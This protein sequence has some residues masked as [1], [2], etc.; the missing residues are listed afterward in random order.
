MANS[1]IAVTN[2]SSSSSNPTIYVC[3]SIWGGDQS[4]AY[5]A[6]KTGATHDFDRSDP[7]GFIMMVRNGEQGQAEPYYVTEYATINA[8]SATQVFAVIGN[9]SIQLQSL[10][11]PMAAGASN[12]ASA[13]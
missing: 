9:T 10:S 13:S 11:Y 5:V 4:T 1:T 3:V 7:R 8:Q 2:N 12:A 6:I